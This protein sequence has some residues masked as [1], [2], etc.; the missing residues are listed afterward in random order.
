MGLRKGGAGAVQAVAS[1]SLSKAEEFAAVEFI[2]DVYGSYQ[3][4]VD[5]DNIDLVYNPLPNSLHA[6]WTIKCLKAGKPVLCEKPFTVTAAEAREVAAV[7]QDT[8]VP[9]VE[10][11]MYRHHP[12]YEE[13]RSLLDSGAIGPLHSL[14][15][16]FSHRLEDRSIVQADPALGGG[17]LMDLGCYCVNAARLLTRM[18]PTRVLGWEYRTNIDDTFVGIL[19]FPGPL[20]AQ[21][22]ASFLT[23]PR[24]G[25]ELLGTKGRI[26]I[27]RPWHSREAAEQ[28]HLRT[29]EGTTVVGCAGDDC[30]RME[31]ADLAQAWSQKRGPRWGVDDAVK[32]MTILESLYLSA[33]EARA[34]SLSP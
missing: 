32:N 28:L 22:E 18:E 14:R 9:A 24:V 12:Q 25:I 17:V 1:R 11:F 16:Q 23:A 8:G 19:E 13:A 2:P 31:A 34:V 27:R 10:A 21:F 15:L 29:A 7:S 5:A 30:F 20:V 6:E 4:L 26:N 33:R 3:E